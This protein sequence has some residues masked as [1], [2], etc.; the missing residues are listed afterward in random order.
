MKRAGALGAIMVI[1][2]VI[3]VGLPVSYAQD[4]DITATSY[5]LDNTIILTVSNSGTSEIY[6]IKLWLA[7]DNS[8]ESFKASGGWVG[9]RQA[10]NL[11]VFNTSLPIGSGESAKF[12]VVTELS[13]AGINWQALDSA[14]LELARD[15]TINDESL[16]SP[17][18]PPSQVNPPP[19]EDVNSGVL[20]A[21][22]FRII[23]TSPNIGSQIRVVGDGFGA[24]KTITLLLG[25]LN[26]TTIDTNDSGRFVHT[27]TIP[28]KTLAD[29]TDFTLTDGTGNTLQKSIRLGE[30][31]TRMVHT[32]SDTLVFNDI[33]STTTGGDTIDLSGTGKPGAFI[34][35]TL[36]H[37]IGHTIKISQIRIDSNG[38]WSTSFPIYA[39]ASAGL[40]TVT[41]TDGA[42]NLEQS[43]NVE[44]AVTISVLPSRI[45]Y[46]PGDVLI[47]RGTA[48]PNEDL[49]VRLVNP[50]NIVLY[51]DIFVIDSSGNVSFEISTTTNYSTGTYILSL[52]QNSQEGITP[53]G[54]GGR[55]DYPFVIKTGNLNY[56]SSDT[57]LITI[58]GAANS[59]ATLSV[60]DPNKHVTY[61]SLP[62]LLNSEGIYEYNLVLS[63]YTRGIYT[64]IVN[65]GKNSADLDFGVNLQY[66]AGAMTVSTI[67]SI[68][69]YGDP[70]IVLGESVKKTSLVDVMLISPSGEERATSTFSDG[71]TNGKF[72]VVFFV[73]S[74]S[75]PGT[76]K[77]ITKSGNDTAETSFE[78]S[79]IKTEEI[80]INVEE[81]PGAAG[82][83]V[84]IT[85]EGVIP[86]QQ[87]QISITH[88]F[89]E[90][91]EDNLLARSTGN[92]VFSVEWPNS[93]NLPPGTYTI[94][95]SDL[96]GDSAE[97][98]W[99]VNQ[100]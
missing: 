85:G 39:S 2:T 76:W 48:V 64:A 16:T 61:T 66:N 97:T 56:T 21:S 79:A 42:T 67:Q 80:I 4:S 19:S 87:I 18:T 84:L 50:Q 31:E 62:I 34:I 88:N 57:A 55:A 52:K 68:Y 11:L 95:V 13:T 99:I 91:I 25:S 53:V 26:L 82:P 78:I 27:V 1:L 92:G 46:N 63:N 100:N 69:S 35:I 90:V 65:Y 8:F 15:K 59:D 93:V 20:D 10:P 6:S 98:T 89:G 77:I 32:L 86:N 75:E 29:R 45:S 47:F 60:V 7:D 9:I 81:I 96:S 23:P 83:S 12:G 58:R 94:Q 72:S 5:S 74:N 70:V 37:P 36:K 43:W 71:E 38:S 17:P 41:A 14:G 73:H 40:Y 54:I 30:A 3:V 22:T 33:P 24:Q 49:L 28:E 51:E 44:N